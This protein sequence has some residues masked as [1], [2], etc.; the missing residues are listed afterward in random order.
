[1]E[2]EEGVLKAGTNGRVFESEGHDR[3]AFAAFGL[4]FGREW[5]ATVF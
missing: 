5:F 4:S 3:W 2:M 1:V